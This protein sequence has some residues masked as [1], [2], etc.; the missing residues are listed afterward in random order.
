MADDKLEALKERITKEIEETI[1]IWMENS[2]QVSCFDVER[3]VPQL[4]KSTFPLKRRDVLPVPAGHHIDVFKKLKATV[5]AW[6]LKAEFM[7]GPANDPDPFAI[8]L[9]TLDPPML[10][11]RPQEST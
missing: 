11:D 2:A 8:L 9:I 5:E 4:Y 3:D 6:G 1:R 7:Y 10:P